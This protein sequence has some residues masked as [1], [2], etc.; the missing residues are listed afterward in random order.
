MRIMAAGVALVAGTARAAEGPHVLSVDVLGRVAATPLAGAPAPG[1]RT[2]VPRDVA[3]AL[4][5]AM[6]SAGATE[7]G[8]AKVEMAANE[9]LVPFRRT[10]I[11]SY[12]GAGEGPGETVPATLQTGLTVTLRADRKEGTFS[13]EWRDVELTGPDRGFRDV[14]RDGVR[15]QEPVTAEE[16]GEG[17]DRLPLDGVIVQR[18]GDVVAFLNWE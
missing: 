4:I 12:L 3:A 2:V 9:T 13:Y 17:T 15:H 8:H 10:R 11:R 16:V 6:R 1:R 14:E 18:S 5:E 7:L